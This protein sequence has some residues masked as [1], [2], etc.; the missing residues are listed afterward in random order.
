MFHNKKLTTGHTKWYSV[1]IS[2]I[3]WAITNKCTYRWLFLIRNHQCMVTNRLKYS[4]TWALLYLSQQLQ[5]QYYWI[6]HYRSKRGYGLNSSGSE[7][8]QVA[9]FCEH[10]NGTSGFICEKFIDSLMTYQ[11]IDD[12]FAPWSQLHIQRLCETNHVRH[13]LR[14]NI[15]IYIHGSV[16]RDSIL[17]RSNEM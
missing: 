8:G 1:R 13:I 4:Y 17:I 15:C 16:H 10:G 2:Y 11:F 14:T 5:I 12:D 3:L 6:L 9:D 7:Y